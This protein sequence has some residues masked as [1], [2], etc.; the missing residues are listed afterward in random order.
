M[1]NELKELALKIFNERGLADTLLEMSKYDI[2][3]STIERWCFPELNDEA[4][5]RAYERHEKLKNDPEYKEKRRLAS[6]KRR[7]SKEG[8]EYAK[9][10]YSKTIDK[11]KE[12]AKKHRADNI[13][14]YTE[15]ASDYYKTHKE[16]YTAS[17]IK[18]KDKRR[19]K[20]LS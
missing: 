14:H 18:N 5:R 4:R 12:I 1:K 17:R 3:Q 11:R 2:R 20:G 16:V 7:A 8:K 9:E 13:E 6:Q 15:R 19:S 10:Y